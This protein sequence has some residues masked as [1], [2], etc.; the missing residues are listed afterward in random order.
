MAPASQL[1]RLL[2]ISHSEQY[3]EAGFKSTQLWYVLPKRTVFTMNWRPISLLLLSKS[4]LSVLSMMYTYDIFVSVLMEKSVWTL[5]SLNYFLKIAYEALGFSFALSDIIY[6][7]DSLPLVLP[8]LCV[9]PACCPHWAFMGSVALPFLDAW[10]T[11]IST[12]T[13]PFCKQ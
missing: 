3:T 2:F 6:F 10:P 1:G 5:K 9:L 11:T 4:K 13:Q 12:H 7:V 8:H